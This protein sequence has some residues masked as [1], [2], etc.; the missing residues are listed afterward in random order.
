MAD[1]G[2]VSIKSILI[3]LFGLVV[4]ALGV[5]IGGTSS[6]MLMMGYFTLIIWGGDETGGHFNPVISLGLFAAQEMEIM[7]SLVY[8]AAHCIGALISY[9]IVWAI[10][11]SVS[12][13]SLYSGSAM[14]DVIDKKGTATVVNSQN[15]NTIIYAN[16]FFC[17]FL[18][19]FLLVVCYCLLKVSKETPQHV[20]KLGVPISI[21]FILYYGYGQA[22]IGLVGCL[23]KRLW[24]DAI[25]YS[26]PSVLGG[27]LGGFIYKKWMK[28]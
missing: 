20:Y 13:P 15:N 7:I 10:I 18:A 9:V 5:A 24:I 19:G 25:F 11:R 6:R 27:M 3:E 14:F 2:G 17:E 22:A 28:A 12:G 26:V 23:F 21:M 1:I 16:T 4:L 8:T